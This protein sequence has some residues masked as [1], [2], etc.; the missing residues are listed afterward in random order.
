MSVKKP[1]VPNQSNIRG[2]I[3]QDATGNPLESIINNP[4]SMGNATAGYNV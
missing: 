1:G 4:K 2:G 3:E